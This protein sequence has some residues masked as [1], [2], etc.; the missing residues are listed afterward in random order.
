M[1]KMPGPA[2]NITAF[3]AYELHYERKYCMTIATLC[4]QHRPHDMKRNITAHMSSLTDK[5]Y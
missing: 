5:Y 4:G 3:I 1:D 2:H